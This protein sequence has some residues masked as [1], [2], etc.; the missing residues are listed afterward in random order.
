MSNIHG[1]F[2]SR[3]EPDS[4]DEGDD[5][6]NNRYVGGVDARGGGSGLA[7][8]PNTSA[9][10]PVN[11]G[12]DM[13]NIS[14][15]IFNVAT[16]GNAGDD[17]QAPRRIIT[18]YR[19]G[20]TV[21]DG[22]YRRVNDPAN[23]EFLSSLARKVKPRELIDE[24]GGSDVS[25]GLVDRR[26]EDYVEEFRSFSG[27]GTSLGSSSGAAGGNSG[28]TIMGVIRPN[29]TQQHQS[30]ASSAGGQDCKTTSVQ[31]RL[32]S[33]RRLI[34]KVPINGNVQDLV[35]EIQNIGGADVGS[36]PYVLMAGFPP[37]QITDLTATIEEAGLAGSSVQQKKIT[38]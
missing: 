3:R 21:D 22:P 1:L 5:E 23:R 13:S 10:R 11:D 9:L 30:A 15:S 7:V 26:S 17:N 14:S 24:G 33:G 2:S 37:R 38:G 35:N 8:E 16:A 20:F 36:E 6:S 31:V 27:A 12:G 4:D 34:A 32:L 25:V 18:M 19:D 28:G 29:E